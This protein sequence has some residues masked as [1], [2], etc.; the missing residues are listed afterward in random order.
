MRS[1]INPRLNGSRLIG[2]SASCVSNASRA[3]DVVSDSTR[4]MSD[5][6]PEIV[7]STLSFELIVRRLCQ[8]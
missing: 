3:K 8:K 5:F 7:E 4:L 1:M 2:A 6:G